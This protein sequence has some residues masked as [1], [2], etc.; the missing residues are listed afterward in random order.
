MKLNTL[1]P[2]TK[3]LILREKNQETLFNHY[4]GENISLHKKYTNPL[5][6]DNKAD[7]TFFYGDNDLVFRDFARRKIYTVFDFVEEKY[8]ISYQETLDKIALDF[9]IKQLP[10]TPGQAALMKIQAKAIPNKTKLKKI[11]KLQDLLPCFSADMSKHLDYFSTM[12]YN[13]S[14]EEFKKYRIHGIDSFYMVFK[15]Y[16]SKI[17]TNPLGFIYYFNKNLT[18]KQVYNPFGE[19]TQK[20]RQVMK[21]TIIGLEFL[22]KDEYVIVT[23]SYKDFVILHI[24]GFNVCCILSEN[25]KPN[26]TDFI[27]LKRYGKVILT[28]FDNDTTG[29]DAGVEW[30]EKF[31]SIAILLSEEMK[32]SYKHYKTFGKEN[33]TET[34]K[35]LIDEAIFKF[36][37][38]HTQ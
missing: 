21:T 15:D 24:C 20:F 11:N 4:F 23:K 16:K 32:D 5:R 30:E 25:Y 6:T 28:L 29:I 12:D 18:E 3:D 34:I 33:L 38:R 14:L 27:V 8:G 36:A 13:V 7:C 2:V 22:R 26:M 1:L 19:K 10:M 9:G 35:I 31:K 17:N 37:R